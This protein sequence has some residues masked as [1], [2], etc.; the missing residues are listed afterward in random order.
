MPTLP[1]RQLARLAATLVL[2]ALGPSASLASAAT[3]VAAGYRDFSF[4][5]APNAPTAKEPQSKLWYA[6]GSWWA[7]LYVTSTGSFHIHRYAASTHDWIDTGTA[8]DE[9]DVTRSDALWDGSHVYIV[10]AGISTGSAASARLLRFSYDPGQQRFT[11]DP[12]FPVTL[13]TGGM[14]SISID[15]DTTGTLWATFVQAGTAYVTHSSGG[16]A[17]WVAPYVLPA[18]GATGL[19]VSQKEEIAITSY[20]GR[21]GLMWSDQDDSTYRY[22]EH[23]DGAPDTVWQSST[24][25]SAPEEADNHINLVGLDGDPAGQ[26]FATVKTSLNSPNAPLYKLLVLRND[27]T[28]AQHTIA[29]VTDNHTRAI[30]QVDLQNRRIYFLAT[31]P[32]CSGGS[33]YQKSTSLD[34]IAFPV[35]KGTVLISSATETKINNTSATKQTLDG[36]TDLVTV[37]SDDAANFYLH[38]ELDLPSASDTTPPETT[39]D[40]GPSGTTGSTSAVF[41]FSANEAS[42]FACRLD[43]AAF[44]PCGS[45]ISYSGLALGTHT[46]DV[47]ATDLA[48]NPDSTPAARQWTVSTGPVTLFS[49]G[50]ETGSFSGWTQVT[51]A[52]GGTAVVQGPVVRTGA[53]AAQLAATSATGSVAYARRTLA[54]APT[55]VRVAGDFHVLQEGASGGNVPLI[56]LL[57]TSGTRVISL[58]RQNLSSN[59]IYVQI[60]GVN[61]LTSGVLPLSTWGRFEVHVVAGAAGAGVVEVTLNGTPIFQ[62]ATG[63]VGT[64]GIATVQ[65]GND[66]AKQTFGLVA[67]DLLVTTG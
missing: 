30:G 11:L 14:E 1:R 4:G 24:A 38:G 23:V 41:A 43:G 28:W 36:T 49:D 59:R 55:D 62:T 16:D 34:A 17:T 27:G 61:S 19:N 54:T 8:V 9:R 60:S 21:I 42:T 39:I 46:F 56:R 44:T 10:T 37:A 22:A 3:P 31:T 53:F 5:A 66:T 12:G 52:G 50:F 6:A 57:N 7:S 58:S 29:R 48:G 65:I 32:C 47:R 13:S 51:T 25:H 67:D 2:A 33:V 15:K 64:T 35:G 20:N 63:T 45:P 26:V 18:T 40:S